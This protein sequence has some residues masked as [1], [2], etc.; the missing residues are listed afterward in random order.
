MSAALSASAFYDDEI[1]WDK[2]DFEF[3]LARLLDGYEVF[4]RTFD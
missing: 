4:I 1:D 3:G 2:A